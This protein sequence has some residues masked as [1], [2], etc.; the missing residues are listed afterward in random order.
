MKPRLLFLVSEDWYFV[1]HRL[2][3]AIAARD[4]GFDVAV[5]TRTA[6]HAEAI[7]DAQISLHPIEMRRS[8][9]NPASALAEL[10]SLNRLYR[11]L[12]PD[13]AH[14]VAM[15][16]IVLGS[17]AARRSG[18]KGVVNTIAGLGYAFTE[19]SA[20]SALLRLPLRHALK[21]ALS[22]PASR[23]IVQSKDDLAAICRARL[24]R[25]NDVRLIPGSGVD[26]AKFDVG[27]PPP[28]PPLIILPARLI[29]HKGVAEFVE[30]ARLLKKQGL[31][32]R[33]ALV[34]APDPHNP[35]SFSDAEIAAFGRDGAVEIWGHRT[36]MP[37]VLR[38]ASI[39]CQPS[40]SE[41]LSKS[42][43]EAIAARRAIVTSDAPGN[44]DLVTAGKTGWLTPLRDH[45]SLAEALRGAIG[46]PE[47]RAA[48]AENAYAEH[49][50]RLD[51]STINT[52]TIAVYEELLRAAAQK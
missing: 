16:P 5:A 49:A 25:P 43:I 37:N 29:R 51:I 38:E 9:L 6:Q 20:A 4:A 48:F 13:I 21:Q 19:T 28:G 52:A 3:L 33:F 46:R 24:V 50:G 10:A 17:R 26:F 40:Y 23:T 31:A 36:D 12:K 45:I 30:A 15:K 35:S 32:A 39:V 47:Q 22:A 1:S 14:N 8:S 42:L 44:R 41:G 2:A 34:G 18:A 27:P 7:R 11:A